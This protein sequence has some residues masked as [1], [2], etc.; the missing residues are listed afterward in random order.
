MTKFYRTFAEKFKVDFSI[1]G[2]GALKNGTCT[3]E[4]I[5]AYCHILRGAVCSADMQK[6]M[7]PISQQECAATIQK[8]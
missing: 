4:V 1:Y 8:W 3:S 7:F 6:R 2:A 5:A